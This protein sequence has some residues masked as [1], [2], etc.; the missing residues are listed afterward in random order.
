MAKTKE[1]IFYFDE[2][3]TLA[4]IFVVLIHICKHFAHAEVAHSLF[5]TFSSSLEAFG[6]MGVPLFFMISGALLL[7]RSYEL[8]SFFKKR[9]SRVLI[10]FA[11]WAVIYLLFKF[12]YLGY[13]QNLYNV[14]RIIFFD[15]FVWFIWTLLGI[16]LFIP[17]INAFI[18]QYG[19]KGCEYFLAIWL[20]TVILNTFGFYPIRNFELSY[21]ARFLG[22]FVLG[23]Y[24]SNKKFNIGNK[25]MM[26]AGAAIFLISLAISMYCITNKIRFKD[27]YWT[28]IPLF[29]SIGLYLLVEYHAKYSEGNKGSVLSRIYYFIKDSKLG[30]IIFSISICSYGIFL[31]HYFP[32]WVLLKLDKTI[33]IFARNPFKWIPFLLVMVLLFSWGLT[34]LLSK[35]PYLKKISGV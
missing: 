7:N 33:P 21:F 26:I 25:S 6:N 8:K 28:L 19:I 3:R 4:I 13:T 27:Y 23:Y 14:Y 17:I 5:W 12:F 11:F 15:G 16:Y 31:T 29:E 34:F 30:R 18:Q 2:L 22:Y 24:L 35:I 1:R 32:I 20:F 10:P 9:Y